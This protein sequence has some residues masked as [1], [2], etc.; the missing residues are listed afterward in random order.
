MGRWCPQR[1][2]TA[3]SASYLIT[4]RRR[5]GRALRVRSKARLLT[6]D[7]VLTIMRVTRAHRYAGSVPALAR[8]LLVALALGLATGPLAGQTIT[9]NVS[10]SARVFVAPSAKLTVPMSVDLTAAGALNLASLQAG[11]T[12]G[13][14][15]LTF[16]SIRVVPSTGF[17]LTPNTANAA[18]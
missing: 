11:L 5:D 8:A 1:N 13:A 6:S 12:W 3:A 14:S 2:C 17:S 9:L 4:W 18:S 16:D 10:D 15:R 7:G